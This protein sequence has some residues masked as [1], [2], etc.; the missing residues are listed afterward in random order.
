[1]STPFVVY[2]AIDLRAG[3]CVRLLRGDYDAETVY[4]DDPAAQARAFAEAGARWIHV[5][6]LDAAKTGEPTNS[7]A[8]ADIVGAVDVPVQVGGGVRTEQ[9]AAALFGI[10]VE[11]VV[12]GTAALERPDLVAS[13]AAEHRVAVGLDGRG[14]K[15]AVH[16]W[17]EE[18]DRT[19][20]DVAR[21]FDGVGVDAVIVTEILR[22]GTL[23][24]PDVAGLSGLLAATELEVIA[25]GGVGS[26]ADVRVLAEVGDHGR[27]LSGVICGRSLYEGTMGLA[28]AI[29][30]VE[31][32]GR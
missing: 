2:P 4:G 6:D 20:A 19:V 26:T 8:I 30:A 21:D 7:Q 24:G 11:R 10:G 22:D 3:R 15:V 29:A 31:E 27:Q 14:G 28:D 23:E 9:A 32:I 18:S 17:T 25:S 1:M 12:I 5:V 16:G 13:L